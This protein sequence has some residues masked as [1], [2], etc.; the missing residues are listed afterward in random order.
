VLGGFKPLIVD[1]LWL[2]VE[3]L[4]KDKQY[5]TVLT[6]LTIIAKLQPHLTAV[7]SYNAY[8]M[9]Y[10]ISN[11]ATT[12]EGRWQWVERGLKYM[13]E[14]LSHNPDHPYLM[15]YLAFFYFHRI[16]QDK[17]LMEQVE[18]T[19]HRSTYLMAA[20]WYH[21]TMEVFQA[22]KADEW[23]YSY[24]I[25]YLASRYFYAFDLLEQRRFDEAIAEMNALREYI[26]TIL[27][28]RAGP[29]YNRWTTEAAGYAELI[30]LFKQE[31]ALSL[32]P[33]PDFSKLEDLLQ[34][35]HTVILVH[36]GLEFTPI[37][38]HIDGLLGLY[39]KRMYYLIDRQEFDNAR[40]VFRALTTQTGKFAANLDKHPLT[41][42]VDGLQQRWKE[43]DTIVTAECNPLPPGRGGVGKEKLRSLY[44]TYIR[45]YS[46]LFDT[47]EENNRVQLLSPKK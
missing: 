11:Q 15:S 14:G 16:P 37:R 1:Y 40:E 8:H 43:L 36:I 10:N 9:L 41:W 12:P 21:K 35:Y 20:Q 2:K 13:E 45:T 17:Y 42:F 46:Y 26:N 31:K 44:E 7:W 25:M 22:Q 28:P 39:L 23:A 33:Q 30:K 34:Q 29:D 24:E 47:T 27:I 18:K 4:Q 38:Q 3:N 32:S 6:L 5:S 19:M